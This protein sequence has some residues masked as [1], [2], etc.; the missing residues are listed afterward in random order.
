LT[1]DI[2]GS[3]DQIVSSL[4]LKN[5]E[6]VPRFKAVI[7]N[8]VNSKLIWKDVK[9]NIAAFSKETKFDGGFTVKPLCSGND[10]E[11]SFC[12]RGLDQFSDSIRKIRNTLSHG[13]DQ[14]TAGMILPTARNISLLRPWVHLIATVAGE[15]V[16][17]KDVS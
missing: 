16:L 10:K 3:V 5:L 14:E 17:Y 15:V 1:D 13:K 12:N 11:A 8:N 6:E 4:G 2:H 7:R 9:E